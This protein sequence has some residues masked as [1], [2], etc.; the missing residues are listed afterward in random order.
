V[1]V[2]LLLWHCPRSSSCGREP[3]RVVEQ[4][5]TALRPLLLLLQQRA[6]RQRLRQLQQQ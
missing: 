6:M 2:H 1:V 3:R 5:V 4:A